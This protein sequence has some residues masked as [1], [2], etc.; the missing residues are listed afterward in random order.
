MPCRYL[1]LFSALLEISSAGLIPDTSLKYVKHTE[2]NYVPIIG[3]MSQESPDELKKY[4]PTYIPASYVGY[5]EQAG[6]R[7]APVKVNQTDDYYISLFKSLNG[8]LFPG[9]EVSILDSGY[10][11]A[12]QIFF[13][14][15]IEAYD[16]G[17]YF[18]LWGTCLGF[19]LLTA[20]A[21]GKNVLKDCSDMDISIPL[22]FEQDFRKGRLYREIPE[23]LVQILATE[24]V[25]ANFHFS[26]LDPETYENTPEL[27]KFYRVLSKNNDKKGS[28]FVSSMEAY[29]YPFY[30]TQ[31][32]PEKNNFIWDP[33]Y[34][35]EHTMHSALVSQYFA[36]FFVDECRKSKHRFPSPELE[37][38]VMIDN[39]KPV[40]MGS[41]T[42]LEY[43]MF[44][45]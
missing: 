19:E 15:A 6:A 23:S 16:R 14:L 37:A 29:R 32:H 30:G 38:K 18:P 26:C 3:I 36:N 5:L 20:L 24:N 1:L 22:H 7:V 4:G 41:P 45:V 21:T 35:L 9:G 31:F 11:K 10:A 34:K 17:D 28:P 13:K 42:F 39:Y 44:D 40:F 12:G 8:V 43:Y 25:T 2:T 33:S 27:K